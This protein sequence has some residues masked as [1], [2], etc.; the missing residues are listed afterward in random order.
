MPVAVWHFARRC[1][2]NRHCRTGRTSETDRSRSAQTLQTVLPDPQ[3]DAETAMPHRRY[4]S[5]V[6]MRDCS[7]V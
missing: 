1:P 2:R 6:H 3:V 5:L 4:F 7:D